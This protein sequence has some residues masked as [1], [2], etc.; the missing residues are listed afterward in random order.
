MKKE[1][2]KKYKNMQPIGIHTLSGMCAMYII[3][4]NLDIEDFVIVKGYIG[5]IHKYKINYTSKGGYF[6]Y[7]NGCRYYIKDFMRL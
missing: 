3:D 2:L 7:C 4:L 1:E 6:T 5:D